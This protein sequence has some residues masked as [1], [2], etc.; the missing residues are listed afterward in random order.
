MIPCVYRHE[1][2]IHIRKLPNLCKVARHLDFTVL[3]GLLNP[4]K[5]DKFTK[6]FTI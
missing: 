6:L 4:D 5:M 3:M 2:K 1:M